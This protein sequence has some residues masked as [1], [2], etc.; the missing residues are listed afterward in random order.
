MVPITISA[1]P[2]RRGRYSLSLA[3]KDELGA[4]RSM[5]ISI[6]DRR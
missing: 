2:L 6:V 1:G 4:S 3:V 5:K